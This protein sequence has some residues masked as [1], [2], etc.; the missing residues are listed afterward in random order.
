MLF[1]FVNFGTESEV[2]LDLASEPNKLVPILLVVLL[3]LLQC[4]PISFLGNTHL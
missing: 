2:N 3:G 1:I 4:L